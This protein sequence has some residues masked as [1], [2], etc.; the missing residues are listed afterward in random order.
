MCELN[1]VLF[2]FVLKSSLIPSNNSLTGARNNSKRQGR[3]SNSG[4]RSRKV[5]QSSPL[6]ALQNEQ[7]PRL[8]ESALA[9]NS[10]TRHSSSSSL[11]GGGD[12][13]VISTCIDEAKSLQ[14]A[15]EEVMKPSAKMKT[16]R[17]HAQSRPAS[18]ALLS[19]DEA[20]DEAE[21]IPLHYVRPKSNRRSRQICLLV[22]RLSPDEM[23]L[24][25]I[26]IF[27]YLCYFR[28]L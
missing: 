6:L 21:E 7:S 15:F 26:F 19:G 12:G 11:S 24:Q 3:R 9:S 16:P 20:E 22:S 13:Q 10:V 25:E 1:V 8:P 18:H 17:K 2:F 4:R 23:V 27:V 28:T 14:P 5:S